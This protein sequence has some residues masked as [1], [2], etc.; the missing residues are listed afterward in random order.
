VKATGPMTH[1]LLT[2]LA[3]MGAAEHAPN[4]RAG[5]IQC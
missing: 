2:Q 4:R 3:L 5:P 1:A